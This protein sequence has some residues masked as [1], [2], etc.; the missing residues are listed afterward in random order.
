MLEDGPDVAKLIV[1]K[2]DQGHRS[3]RFFKI[4][5]FSTLIFRPITHLLEWAKHRQQ[6]RLTKIETNRLIYW[7]EVPGRPQSVFFFSQPKLHD[8]IFQYRSISHISPCFFSLA[9]QMW[10]SCS[11]FIYIIPKKLDFVQCP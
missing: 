2:L 8:D 6:R 11:T 5:Q 7:T 9:Y 3:S 1:R 10:I 4:S